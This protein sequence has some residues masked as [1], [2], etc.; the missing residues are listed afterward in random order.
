MPMRYTDI[1][2]V[3]G[4]L[5]GATAAAMLG[6][7]GIAALLIDPHDVYPADFRCEKIDDGQLE[8]LKRTGL[9]DAVLPAATLGDHIWLARFGRLVDKRPHYQY[10]IAYADLVNTMRTAIAAPC[11]FVQAKTTSLSAS[12]DRQTVT[13]STGES[14]S[15]RLV[16]LATGLNA[17][18]RRSVGIERHALSNCHSI[19]IGF[20]IL[21][22]G[23]TSFPFRALTYFP[24]SPANQM[25][26][27]TLF[28]VGHA[29]RANYFVYRELRDPWLQAM[30]TAPAATLLADLPRLVKITGDFTVSSDVEV[31]PVDLYTVT[32]YLQP[33]VVLA[34]DAFATS[35]PAAGTGISKVLTDVERLCN[36]Y[37]PKWLATPGMGED[38]IAEYYADPMKQR[39]DAASLA[40]AYFL[41]SLS[42]EPGAVWGL[43]RLSRFAGHYGIGTLRWMRERTVLPPPRRL[44]PAVER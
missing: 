26:Y 2:I 42:T 7:A 22:A 8:C 27:L 37:I 39:C 12:A 20:D 40:R 31:R 23:K 19:S 4:G 43:R 13:L 9:A 16:L 35:C 18:L 33:G 29:M 44:Q 11:G 41:R 30:R 21:S 17:A 1:A 38:K 34:G 6:R 25:A 15:A 32:G 28:P 10:G 14:I 36:L 24:E 3:G 5:A